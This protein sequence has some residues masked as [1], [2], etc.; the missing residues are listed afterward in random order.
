MYLSIVRY[1]KKTPYGRRLIFNLQTSKNP[2]RLSIWLRSLFSIYDLDDLVQLDVP[3]W[4]LRSSNLVEDFLKSRP[5][6]KA[7]EWGSG[8]S[9]IW[10]AKRCMSVI[11]IEHDPEWATN[12]SKIL[13]SNAHL[14]LVGTRPAIEVAEP[15]I[16]RKRGFKDLDFTEYVEEIS[17]INEKFDLIV[18]DGRAREFCFDLA[19]GHLNPGGLILFDNVERVRYRKAIKHK[20]TEIDVLWTMG[21]TPCLPYPSQTALISIRSGF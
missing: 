12:L 9:S 11:S 8:A 13:P 3:W 7:F 4:T 21:L 15:K 19:L 14:R 20:K 17:K 10:L 1:V 16:S 2:S 5:H 6:P 18:V